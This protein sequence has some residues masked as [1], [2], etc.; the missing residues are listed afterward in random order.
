MKGLFTDVG[1]CGGPTGKSD[2][3]K[4]KLSRPPVSPDFTTAGAVTFCSGI[5]A[6]KHKASTFIKRNYS[7]STDDG[8]MCFSVATIKRD[9]AHI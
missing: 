9:L 1:L 5:Q 7:Q 2:T 6:H 4:G 8:L 3:F